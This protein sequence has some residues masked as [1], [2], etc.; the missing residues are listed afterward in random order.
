MSEFQAPAEF[1][2]ASLGYTTPKDVTVGYLRRKD[3]C[4]LYHSTGVSGVLCADTQGLCLGVRGKASSSSS[5][6]ISSLANKAAMLEPG[7]SQPV[8]LL[9]SDNSQCLIHRNNGV[10]LA[11][12]KSPETS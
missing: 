8:I 5:G 12:Y 2:A 1:Q 11:I 7:N 10:T 9:E 4:N 6:V 3:I